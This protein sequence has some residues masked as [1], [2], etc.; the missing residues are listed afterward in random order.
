MDRNCNKQDCANNFNPVCL[1]SSF[2][3]LNDSIYFQSPCHAGCTTH[4][5]ENGF[6]D[7]KCVQD[8]DNILV[9]LSTPKNGR[10]FSRFEFFCID[11]EP[12]CR[13][14]S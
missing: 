14:L 9:N 4:I 12:K 2:Q 5:G 10:D 3:K 6:G 13:E 8:F 1:P 11:I 7:C